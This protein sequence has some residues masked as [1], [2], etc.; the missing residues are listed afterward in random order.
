VFPQV[1]EFQ[2][3]VVGLL[4]VGLFPEAVGLFPEVVEL[5]TVV[6]EWAKFPGECPVVAVS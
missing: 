1:G 2:E 4:A 6:V 3:V 5:S